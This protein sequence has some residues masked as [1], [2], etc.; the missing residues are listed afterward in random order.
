MEFT[1]AF[2]SHETLLLFFV[3]PAADLSDRKVLADWVWV[4]LKEVTVRVP[5]Y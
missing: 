1:L 4:K 2:V 5:L 3:M